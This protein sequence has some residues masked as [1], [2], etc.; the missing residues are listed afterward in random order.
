MRRPGNDDEATY[1]YLEDDVESA[2]PLHYCGR[3]L[4]VELIPGSDG[5]CGPTNGPQCQSCRRFQIELD[6][7]TLKGD[8]DDDDAR[9]SIDEDEDE[10]EDEDSDSDEE[11]SDEERGY[12]VAEQ[13][14]DEDEAEK[15]EG[16]EQK[17]QEG[18]ED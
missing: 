17:G 3:H 7:H 13:E 12:S 10:D 4:G 11:S 5:Q 1:W 6:S 18:G 9:E 16:D 15:G 14:D 2:G 8:D